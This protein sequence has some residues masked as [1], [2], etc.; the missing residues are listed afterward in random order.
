LFE[1]DLFGKPVSTFP[2]HALVE[3]IGGLDQYG[4]RAVNQMTVPHWLIGLVILALPA[5]FMVFAF[6]Q[7][8]KVKPDPNNRHEPAEWAGSGD[9]HS[10][11]DGHAG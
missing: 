4:E 9:G 6:R 11:H 3:L 10:G 5:A 7:G 8:Q 2:D 1:H